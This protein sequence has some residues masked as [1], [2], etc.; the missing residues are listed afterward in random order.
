[1][2][3]S[4]TSFPVMSDFIFLLKLILFN[5]N[6]WRYSMLYLVDMF[7]IYSFIIRNSYFWS[8]CQLTHPFCLNKFSRNIAYQLSK[9]QKIVCTT[10]IWSSNNFHFA[11]MILIQKNQEVIAWL[12]YGFSQCQW[13]QH[14]FVCSNYMERSQYF[15]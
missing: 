8:T 13:T 3:V 6:L 12:T 1:M 14:S 7:S 10:H 9:I 2:L 11:H 15:L 5:P 4:A